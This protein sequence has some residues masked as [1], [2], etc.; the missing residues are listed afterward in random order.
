[1]SIAE[2]RR[3]R[4]I[5]TDATLT[6]GHL[7]FTG[8]ADPARASEHQVMLEEVIRELQQVSDVLAKRAGR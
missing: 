1:M 2:N 7:A 4:I 8:I 5:L 6:L 3:L